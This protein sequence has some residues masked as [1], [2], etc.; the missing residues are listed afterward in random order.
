M[1]IALNPQAQTVPSFFKKRE[2]SP[3]AEIAV[4]PV[5]PLVSIGVCLLIVVP[6]PSCPSEFLPH[7]CG[8]LPEHGNHME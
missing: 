3:P 1:P 5:K 7:N 4:T 8:I 2:C 6:S